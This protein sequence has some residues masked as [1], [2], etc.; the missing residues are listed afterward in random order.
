MNPP[1]G[2]LFQRRFFRP[3]FRQRQ[4]HRPSSASAFASLLSNRFLGRLILFM[5]DL[6]VVATIERCYSSF[7]TQKK[8]K[9][10]S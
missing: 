7:S 1:A 5:L 9:R 3:F 10:N 4:Q 6:F 8:M 2:A